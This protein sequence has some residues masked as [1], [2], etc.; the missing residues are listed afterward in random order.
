MRIL[1]S[2]LTGVVHLVDILLSAKR[3]RKYQASFG[4]VPRTFPPIAQLGPREQCPTLLTLLTRRS[5]L[6]TSAHS[7][8]RS[9]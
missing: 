6:N 5:A 1:L 8:A 4:K 3:L 2:R 7:S 9:A